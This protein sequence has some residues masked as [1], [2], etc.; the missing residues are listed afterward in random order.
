MQASAPIASTDTLVWCDQAAEAQMR[1]TDVAHASRCTPKSK[2]FW[3]SLCQCCGGMH[4]ISQCLLSLCARAM[5]CLVAT[6]C[7]ELARC[8]ARR[9]DMCGGRMGV[10]RERRA[11][12]CCPISGCDRC[13]PCGADMR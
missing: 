5:C 13:A 11:A 12:R 7:T 4:L 2:H 1:V 3:S 8:E 6:P 10:T 9:A